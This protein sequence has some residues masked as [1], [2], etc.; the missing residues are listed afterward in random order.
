MIQTTGVVDLEQA[1]ADAAGLFAQSLG[2][3]EIT[4]VV[5]LV[6]TEEFLKFRVGRRAPVY[7]HALRETLQ[8]LPDTNPYRGLLGL[9]IDPPE[10]FPDSME[11]NVL[12]GLLVRSTRPIAGQPTS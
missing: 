5:E 10:R 1:Q 3:P 6:G 2:L 8:G 11:A 12:R 7:D 9:E 4:A